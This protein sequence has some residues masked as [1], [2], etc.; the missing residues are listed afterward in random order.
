[1]SS[2]LAIILKSIFAAVLL[3]FLLFRMDLT[4]LADVVSSVNWL[5]ATTAILIHLALVA[6]STN[7]WRIV[8]S[9][10]DINIGFY[11]G[12]Q[13]LLIGY[14]FNLFLPSSFGTCSI[15]PTFFISSAILSSNSLPRSL[16]VISLP[17]KMIETFALFLSSKKRLICRNLN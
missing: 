12:A 14:F 7:R 5:L 6:L 13:M 1:M 17:R 4:K 15:T 11:P 10:F 3:G 8:L 16:W 2:R 9:N